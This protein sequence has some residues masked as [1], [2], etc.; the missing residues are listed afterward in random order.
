MGGRV[1]VNGRTEQGG[2]AAINTLRADL[3]DP[4]LLPWAADNGTAA[5]WADQR[6]SHPFGRRAGAPCCL[7]RL[8]LWRG[9]EAADI[10]A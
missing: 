1:I 3:P 7:M 2:V 10:A 5:D 8:S 4:D 6:Y 9:R